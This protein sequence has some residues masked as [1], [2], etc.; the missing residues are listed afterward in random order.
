MRLTEALSRNYDNKEV[1]DEII[2]SIKGVISWPLAY[3]GDLDVVY[4]DGEF[5]LVD[6]ALRNKNSRSPVVYVNG[7]LPV[8]VNFGEYVK[9]GPANWGVQLRIEQSTDWSKIKGEFMSVHIKDG[10]KLKD[11]KVRTQNL[12]VRGADIKALYI[13]HVEGANDRVLIKDSKIGKLDGSKGTEVRLFN[14]KIN[15]ISNNINVVE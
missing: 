15:T 13:D 1:V 10:V 8:E 12:E 4:E 5:K 9:I 3:E 14:N 6:D 2:N 7:V 11:V